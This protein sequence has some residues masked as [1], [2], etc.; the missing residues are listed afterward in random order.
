MKRIFAMILVLS[1]L[2]SGCALL[3]MNEPAEKQ[4]TA[5]TTAATEA[6]QREMPAAEKEALLR[7]LEY[8]LL[9]AAMDAED[10]HRSMQGWDSV[11]T[12]AYLGDY[13]GD[14]NEELICG[15]QTHIFDA[16]ART[17][18]YRFSQNGTD[19]Y[20]DREGRLY[21]QDDMSGAYDYTMDGMQVEGLGESVWYS[22][23][24]GSQWLTVLSE[25]L[26]LTREM[27]MDSND[28][29]LRY[30]KTIEEKR[31]YK[32]DDAAVT[33]EAYDAKLEEL[34]LKWLNTYASS[35]MQNRVDAAYADDLLEDIAVYLGNIYGCRRVELDM[36]GDGETETLFVLIG[37]LVQ[38]WMDCLQYDAAMES[39]ESA[40]FNLK[41]LVDP[42]KPRTCLLVADRR[43]GQL[44]LDAL[45]VRER[46]SVSDGMDIRYGNGFWWLEGQP[47][48]VNGGFTSPSAQGL[49]SYI[50]V[51]GYSEC[52]IRT[53]DVSA[54]PGNEYLCLC[55]RDGV[56]YLLLFVFEDGGLRTIYNRELADTAVYLLE[57]DGRQCLL[58]Y[59]Q[60]SSGEYTSY[61]YELLG[62][63]E[64]GCKRMLDYA[65]VG[66]YENE[67]DATAVA[68]FFEKLKVYLVKIVVLR[69]PYRLNGRMWLKQEE[70]ELGT[71][72][73]EE[74]DTQTQPDGEEAVMGFVQINDPGS[75][76]NLREGPGTDYARVLVD[77]ADPNSFVKQALGAPV[78]VL[79]TVETGDAAN[80]VW[81]KVRISY[82]DR[83]YVGYSSKTYIRIPGE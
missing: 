29:F 76:L 34:G 2:L 21:L 39:L 47:A 66:Y 83:E 69:D 13:N 81:V 79:E 16:A 35:H 20:T 67:A 1:V 75:W 30:G 50:K 73:Q 15:Y 68:A 57:Q 14:G 7:R 3:K 71:V 53:V 59:S 23:W 64:T 77:P 6:A 9:C 72:P 5:T 48:Y 41:G 11:S 8:A 82:G 55:R 22:K 33:G 36:D 38:P 49:E 51:F 17:N 61:N 80:P 60:Y 70:A 10:R 4:Y 78:T 18:S 74:A 58:V 27:I 65:H 28:R 37:D 24:D 31:T 46:I 19:Y 56:W 54:L 52:I 45:C 32:V 62:F 25:D 63:D 40:Q 44:V 43:D 12:Q 26:N 42:E